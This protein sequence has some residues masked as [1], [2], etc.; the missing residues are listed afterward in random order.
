MR[1]ILKNKFS[2]A[3]QPSCVHY[4]ELINE[5]PDGDETMSIVA[6]DLLEKFDTKDQNGWVVLV[7]DGKTYQH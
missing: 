6:E 2:D 1:S 4:T 5:N 7:G 3:M